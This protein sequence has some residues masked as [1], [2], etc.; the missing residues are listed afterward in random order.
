MVESK[1]WIGLS[2]V[3]LI[4]ILAGAGYFINEKTY[5]CSERG[6]VMDCARFSASGNRCYPSLTVNTGYKDCNNW[7]KINTQTINDLLNETKE[8]K[9]VQVYSIGQG[10]SYLCPPR[11]ENK[12][13]S[14]I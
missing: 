11:S 13:C 10:I 4:G 7:T 1:T 9:E 2:A 6:I 14:R 3:V 12:P 8:I 5:F